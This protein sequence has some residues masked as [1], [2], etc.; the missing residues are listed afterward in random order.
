RYR[1]FGAEVTNEESPKISAEYDAVLRH[2]KEMNSALVSGLEALTEEERA[3]LDR[4][5]NMRGKGLDILP[6]LD[7]DEQRSVLDVLEAW[8]Q[9]GDADQKQT[10]LAELARLL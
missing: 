9:T 4:E 3:E 5:L 6:Q 2:L 10:R 8:Q 7:E 1:E